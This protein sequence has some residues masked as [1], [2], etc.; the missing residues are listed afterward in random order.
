MY[1]SGIRALDDLA[2]ELDKNSQ[3]T[4]GKL[5]SQVLMHSTT[6]DAVSI[7][8]CFFEMTPISSS[9]IFFFVIMFSL[10]HRVL[11][12]LLEKQISYLMNFK[13]ALIS[14]RTSWLHLHSS[15]VRLVLSSS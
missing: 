5:N 9:T 10:L 6:L 3:S 7:V 8:G 13:A 4:Y 14:K 2:G 1:G 12:L 15:S 11:K